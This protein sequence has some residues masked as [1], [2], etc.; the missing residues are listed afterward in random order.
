MG[1]IGAAIA[2]EMLEAV[3]SGSATVPLT[4]SLFSGSVRGV[5]RLEAPPMDP[6]GK[7]TQY[8]STYVPRAEIPE[9]RPTVFA[10]PQP[11][12]QDQ[13][14]EAAAASRSWFRTLTGSR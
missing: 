12:N 6:C 11:P 5:S 4:A 1:Q 10:L 2:I 8:M 3:I 14:D 13:L 7:P 9:I